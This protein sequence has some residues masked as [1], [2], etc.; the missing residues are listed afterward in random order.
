LYDD[1]ELSAA[2]S[3]GPDI[4]SLA[5]QAALFQRRLEAVR[6]DLP[7]PG[8]DWYPYDSLGSF[9]IL[10]D[11]LT[12][13]SRRLLDLIADKP[14]LDIGCGDG[15]IAFFLES[16]G[17][18]VIALDNPQTNYNRMQG[19]RA[20]KAALNSSVEIIEQDIDYH[21]RLPDMQFGVT[22]LFGVLYHLKNPFNVLET[23]A[24]RSR[25]CFLSTRV[26][27]LTARGGAD[28]GEFP[29]AYLVDESET[30]NDA[31]NY[32]IFTSSGLKRLMGRSGWRVVDYLSA[33]NTSASDPVTAEGDERAFCLAERAGRAIT[34]GVLESGW[35]EQEGFESWRWTERK[36]CAV[37]T[38]IDAGAE[39]VLSLEFFLPAALEEALGAV[40]LTATINGFPLPARRFGRAGHY[41]YKERAPEASLSQRPVKVEFML[42]KALAPSEGDS[43]ELGLVVASIRLS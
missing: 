14:V 25:Y 26:T 40:E 35:H 2:K 22:F 1:G 32:W 8:F 21:F 11:L 19:V 18:R 6:A 42:D 9:Y 4:R 37:F 31:T 10:A 17:C 15:H 20:L 28:I 24:T 3:S 33:G 23:L 16:L 7:A 27:R 13:D 29:V 43:R 38:D 12:G 41:Q 39:H 36:F 30:N 34:N 5:D